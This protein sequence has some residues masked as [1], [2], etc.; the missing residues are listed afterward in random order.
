MT[1]GKWM[2][3][4]LLAVAKAL[5]LAEEPTENLPKTN[6]FVGTIDNDNDFNSSLNDINGENSSNICIGE[7]NS[8]CNITK[9]NE[10]QKP[11]MDV[12]MDY[13]IEKDDS[14]S[15]MEFEARQ[16]ALEELYQ[17]DPKENVIDHE[18]GSE[19][20]IDIVHNFIADRDPL[21]QLFLSLC[22]LDPS[23]YQ[24][25]APRKLES[26]QETP[27]PLI[28]E[29]EHRLMDKRKEAAR[30]LLVELI[31]SVV[32]ENRRSM[33]DAIEEGVATR[34]VSVIATKNIIDSIKK[35]WLGV[36]GDMEYVKST[37]HNILFSLMLDSNKKVGS[38]LDIARA[39][40]KVPD[41]TRKLYKEA[42]TEG[43]KHYVKN[44]SW[45]SWR[46]SS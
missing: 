41:Y 37:T 14:D 28:L 19:D 2:L 21:L 3:Y 22:F 8:L 5:P 39:L 11:S 25:E 40:E 44:Q 46:K 20:I 16:K 32:E 33:F 7:L 45:N 30:N 4:F 26:D 24:L 42:S 35:I 43:Y 15:D 18:L 31:D 10:Q 1:M 38:V 34:G 6:I 36:E 17:E 9:E 29:L 27:S 13:P 12:V 23:C